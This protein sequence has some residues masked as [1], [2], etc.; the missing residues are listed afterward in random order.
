MCRG[1][2]PHLRLQLLEEVHDHDYF[3]APYPF[4]RIH[5]WNG[6]FNLIDGLI[7]Q[8]AITLF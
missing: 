4:G 7:L 5:S 3:A 1:L 8:T 6:G 2:L